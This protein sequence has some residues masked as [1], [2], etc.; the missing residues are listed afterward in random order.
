MDYSGGDFDKALFGE[1]LGDMAKQ[2]PKLIWPESD[3]SGLSTRRAMAAVD[4]L[5]N[6]GELE[7]NRSN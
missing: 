7:A 3:H 1:L 4:G 5:S 2:I 6:S